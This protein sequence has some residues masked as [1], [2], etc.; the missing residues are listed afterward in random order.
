MWVIE[1]ERQGISYLKFWRKPE[2]EQCAKMGPGGE[3]GNSKCIAK[4][5]FQEY[6]DHR[7]KQGHRAH[8]AW[9]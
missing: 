8:S 4:L 7:A 3:R 5:R 9:Q 2:T 6:K 1:A